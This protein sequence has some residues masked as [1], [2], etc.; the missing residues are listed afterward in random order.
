MPMAT[1]AGTKA[2]WHEAG[3]GDRA[4]FL[5]HCTM[6]HSGAWKGVMRALSETCR[7]VAMDLPAHGQSG[8]RD[9]RVSWQTQSVEMVKALLERG[10]TP[11]DLVG[12]SFGATVCLRVALERPELV[13]SL[14]LIEPVFFSAAK[15]A[16]RPEYGEHLGAHSY[17]Y[18]L[19]D[20]GDLDGAARAFSDIWS[21][22][23]AW[24]DLPDRQRAYISE[25]VGMIRVGAES[26]I[27]EGPDYIP[28]TRLGALEAPVLLVEGD[29]TDPI[30]AAVHDSLQSV[31]ADTSRV[32][33][34]NA[35]HMVPI[36]HPVEVA[37]AITDFFGP[38]EPR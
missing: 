29:A 5:L 9:P 24:D 28:L 17:F 19:L 30:I 23:V 25:R 26:L 22:P 10:G 38:S 27:G 18:E 16:G 34:R 15:D 12:H 13:R 31:L 4:V 6:A 35:G 21:G 20:K 32:V 33:V 2:F 37:R 3:E 1:L 7:M 36:T 11:H 14:T 8:P